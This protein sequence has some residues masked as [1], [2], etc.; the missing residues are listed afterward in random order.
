[1]LAS[2]VNVNISIGAG[3]LPEASQCTGDMLC[4]FLH[5][6]NRLQK[7]ALACKVT[8]QIE[9]QAAG[10][11]RRRHISDMRTCTRTKH[12]VPAAP[13][14]HIQT[15]SCVDGP[16]N[17][18]ITG[19]RCTQ[20]AACNPKKLRKRCHLAP[21]SQRSVPQLHA[22][23]HAQT[24][25]QTRAESHAPPLSARQKIQAT[26]RAAARAPKEGQLLETL[27]RTR[28]RDGPRRNL[29]QRPAG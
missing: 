21:S 12:E 18:G 8:L 11:H 23:A 20:Q 27:G 10:A 5:N 24:H 28:R 2:A 3:S 19:R 6:N 22:H 7:Q 4:N 29:L 16:G 26:A 25:A 14:V 15:P 13:A 1:M 9:W 17:L